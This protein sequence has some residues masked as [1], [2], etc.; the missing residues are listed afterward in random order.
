M[1]G[2]TLSTRRN[3]SSLSGEKRGG[4]GRGEEEEEAWLSQVVLLSP[5]T[6]I[7]YGAR[8][9]GNKSKPPHETS[10]WG[11]EFTDGPPRCDLLGKRRRDR[12]RR[13]GHDKVTMGPVDIMFNS[14][15]FGQ[16]GMRSNQRTV[17]STCPRLDSQRPVYHQHINTQQIKSTGLKLR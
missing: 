14:S 8:H 4:G 10:I 2:G 17:L 16:T 7:S 15:I 11:K 6:L 9:R 12:H 13:T 5:R 1:F 3:Q